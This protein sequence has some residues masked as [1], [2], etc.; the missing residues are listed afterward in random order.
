VPTEPGAA[1]LHWTDMTTTAD[2]RKLP[3]E[4]KC[5]RLRRYYLVVGIVC[6]VFFAVFG[7][8]STVV[9]YLNIDGSFPRPHLAALVF[10]VFWSGFTLLG[11]WVIAAY[12]RERL[13]LDDNTIVLNSTFRSKTLDVGDV[14]QVE[15]RISPVGGSIVVRTRSEKVKIYLDNFTKDD[16]EQVVFFFRK[17][18]A[19]E[20]QENWSLFEERARRLSATER[21]VPRGGMMVIASIFMCLAGLFVYCWFAGLGM[22]YL[23][24]GFVNAIAAIWYVWRFRAVKDRT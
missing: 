8:T 17:T 16:R 13:F 21:R 5:F 20:V 23:F 15:W 7:V 11:L 12:F 10:G 22:Q 19:N 6:A 1:H 9:A 2:I 3:T 14:V 18:F 24:I 4:A